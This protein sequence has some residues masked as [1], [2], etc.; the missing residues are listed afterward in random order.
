MG[1]ALHL[2]KQRG[3][4][5]M[6]FFIIAALAALAAADPLVERYHA[7]EFS[8]FMNKFGKTNAT[9]D[10]SKLRFD[11]FK[12]N[13]QKMNA[14]N[15]RKDV[16]WKMGIN[17]FSDLTDEEFE[18]V[19]LGGYK[20]TPTPAFRPAT[21]KSKDEIN[22]KDLPESVNWC[23]KGACTP[24]KD[25]GSCGSCWAFATTAV[26]ESHMQI[27]TGSL[28]KLS[29]QQ[30]TSCTPNPLKC[31][32]TGGCYG[33]IPQLGYTYIQLFGQISEDDYPYVSGS[34]T[35]TEDC[36][37]NLDNL[38]PVAGLSG[39]NILEPNSV[40]A[41]MDF[42]ANQGPLA[43][44]VAASDWGWYSGG[45]FDGCSY[46]DNIA[47]NHAVVL[48]GYGTDEKEGD[49]WIVRNSWGSGWGENGHIRL[50]RE[51]TA[52]CGVNS[53]PMD[54]TACVGGPG[55]DQQTVCGMCGVLYD[56]SYPLG[57][58]LIKN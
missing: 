41:V 26:I 18:A 51:S 25:Q 49:Y 6:K 16:S 57:A 9:S 46:D 33:S 58:H 34:S 50:K 29:T 17:Q 19:H 22:I 11:I 12:A 47:L 48:V 53:T 14:H 42:V 52:T 8:T 36:E 45:V 1:I 27:A 37:Y 20:Q 44:A 40:E 5:I 56:V 31:G 23:D 10:E 28:P 30:V 2:P 21:L 55:N 32:G 24:V 15:S 38:T 54:G 7:K 3:H 39:Y 4:I 43:V 35:Q 13:L